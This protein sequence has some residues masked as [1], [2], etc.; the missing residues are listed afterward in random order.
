MLAFLSCEHKRAGI[1]P[2]G[3]SRKGNQFKRAEI[4][5]V[6]WHTVVHTYYQKL[7]IF[8]A[9]KVLQI[10]PDRLFELKSRNSSRGKLDKSGILHSTTQ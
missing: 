3:I 10:A 4:V 2:V 7:P 8:S 1:V 6:D 9:P 5:P